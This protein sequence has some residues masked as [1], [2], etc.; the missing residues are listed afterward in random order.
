MREVEIKIGVDFVWKQ[1]EDA[2]K[3]LAERILSGD[4]TTENIQDVVSFKVV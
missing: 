1:N 4:I 2:F 3:E